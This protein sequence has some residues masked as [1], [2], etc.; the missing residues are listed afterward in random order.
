MQWYENVVVGSVLQSVFW[1]LFLAGLVFLGA[2]LWNHVHGDFRESFIH[3]CLANH[4]QVMESSHGVAR[5]SC[6]YPE[7][8]SPP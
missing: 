3:D 1:T 7:G 2:F 5:L 8:V 6:I 4:G